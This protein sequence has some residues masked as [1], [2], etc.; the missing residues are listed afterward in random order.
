VPLPIHQSMQHPG[1]GS[2]RRQPSSST[3][4]TTT[5][6]QRPAPPRTP[7]ATHAHRL[8]AVL[9][10]QHTPSPR[11]S[12]PRPPRRPLPHP[13]LRSSTSCPSFDSRRL[14][15]PATPRTST[16]CRGTA[17]NA[18]DWTQQDDSPRHLRPL[19][20]P[21]WQTATQRRP[22]LRA[23]PLPRRTLRCVRRPME[24]SPCTHPPQM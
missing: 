15:T 2:N 16:S 22:S 11:A 6:P 5:P 21:P 4:L 14:C 13:Q 9:A 19:T 3:L 7:V 12:P 20:S 10:R 17:P 24:L 23:R 18:Y 1:S 8:S